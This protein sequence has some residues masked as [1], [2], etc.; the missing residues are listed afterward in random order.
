MQVPPARRLPPPTLCHFPSRCIWCL[1]LLASPWSNSAAICIA[2]PEFTT[3]RYH[4]QHFRLL[5][6]P[7][8]FLPCA[9]SSVPS[10][11]P[12]LPPAV[13]GVQHD[14]GKGK[15]RKAKKKRPAAASWS[16]ETLSLRTPC[17]K[18]PPHDAQQ[19]LINLTQLPQPLFQRLPRPGAYAVRYNLPY[20]TVIVVALILR[21]NHGT[22]P[23][24]NDHRPRLPPT[25]HHQHQGS[26]SKLRSPP[27]AAQPRSRRVPVQFGPSQR[28]A[29]GC[30]GVTSLPSLPPLRRARPQLP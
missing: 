28:P 24:P 21:V 8:L 5:R 11:L 6:L 13:V 9:L 4:F 2:L 23:P 14:E 20:L 22:A 25:T 29:Q 19:Y 10:R 18:S 27:G 12:G 30:W 3:K 7:C 16:R 1:P 26:N 15:S 17:L